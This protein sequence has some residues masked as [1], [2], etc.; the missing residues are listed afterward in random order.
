[1]RS[2]SISLPRSRIGPITVKNRIC[3]SAHS[4]FFASD[5][6]PTE[7][8]AFYFAERAMGVGWIV[9]GGSTAHPSSLPG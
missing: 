4:N 8:Q 7:P 9:V 2:S 6:L 3:Y 5:N 1:M